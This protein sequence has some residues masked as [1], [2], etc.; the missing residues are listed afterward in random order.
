MRKRKAGSETLGMNSDF[1]RWRDQLRPTRACARLS[2]LVRHHGQH[3]CVYE[4][5]IRK[6]S[7]EYIVQCSQYSSRSAVDNPLLY[8]SM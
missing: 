6:K 2:V 5:I 4:P 1:T 3:L 8:R 7:V